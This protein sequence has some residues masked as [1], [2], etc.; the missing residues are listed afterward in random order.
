MASRKNAIEIALE[1]KEVNVEEVI[2][3][4]TK[5]F[6]KIETAYNKTMKTFS[7]RGSFTRGLKDLKNDIAEGTKPAEELQ[8][9]FDSLN[10]MLLPVNEKIKQMQEGLAAVKNAMIQV[11]E[12]D[13]ENKDLSGLTEQYKLQSTALNKISKTYSKYQSQLKTT[14]K[15]LKNLEKSQKDTA[16]ATQENTEKVKEQAANLYRLNAAMTI[17]RKTLKAIY[18]VLTSTS[19]AYARNAIS[20]KAYELSFGNL[21]DSAENITEELNS[22][23]DAL[24]QF[25][26]NRS[27]VQQMAVDFYSLATAVGAGGGLAKSI[28]D[29]GNDVEIPVNAALELILTQPI[30][31]NPI[32]Q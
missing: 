18:G 11:Q 7:S 20:M 31:V 9:K 30:T 6:G 24:E 16:K 28:W 4:I 13:P 12:N 8:N 22:M 1:V 26:Y 25:G 23:V 14:G 17:A 29:K 27:D 15:E 19:D 10:D 32:S 3:K 2:G 5:E 21:G